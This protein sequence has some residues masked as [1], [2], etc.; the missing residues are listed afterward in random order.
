MIGCAFEWNARVDD[1]AQGVRQF[2]SP[3]INN[4]QMVQARRTRGGRRFASSFPGVQSNVMVIP[5]GGKKRCLASETLCEFKAKHVAVKRQ[6]P[7]QIGYLQMNVANFHPWMK[8]AGAS[9]RIHN[10]LPGYAVPHR[11]SF[12]HMPRALQFIE[13]GQPQSEIDSQ[14][15]HFPMCCQ[16]SKGSVS[17]VTRGEHLISCTRRLEDAPFFARRLSRRWNW[18]ARAGLVPRHCQRDAGLLQS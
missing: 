15:S 13:H 10:S 3:R 9:V 14:T 17:V 7:V 4:R 1:A 11:E 12:A 18:A 8:R 16:T 2:R 6:R 5:T